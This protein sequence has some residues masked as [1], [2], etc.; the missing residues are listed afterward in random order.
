MGEKDDTERDEREETPIPV[1]ICPPGIAHNALGWWPQKVSVHT[2]VGAPCGWKVTG[3]KRPQGSSYGVPIVEPYLSEKA[4]VAM[5]KAWETYSSTTE[6]VYKENTTEAQRENHQHHMRNGEAQKAYNA[7][8]NAKHV[9]GGP[10][11]K[12]EP[13]RHVDPY[14]RDRVM[15]SG[16]GRR[17]YG[18]PK[19]DLFNPL[20]IRPVP[21]PGPG[22]GNGR[23][24]KGKRIGPYHQEWKTNG[25]WHRGEGVVMGEQM[26]D[27]T[28]G[29]LVTVCL[30]TGY[31][32]PTEFAYHPQ[33]HPIVTKDVDPYKVDSLV[34]SQTRVVIMTDHSPHFVYQNLQAVIRKRRLIYTH[35]KS[36]SAIA[37][38]LQKLLPKRTAKQNGEDREAARREAEVEA[39]AEQAAAMNGGIEPGLSARAAR[40]VSTGVT[41]GKS[42]A[43]GSIAAFI[44]E[45]ADLRKG[46]AEEARRLFKIAQIQGVQTTLGS[47]AQGISTIKRKQGRG[48]IPVSAQPVEVSRPVQAQTGLEV[49]IAGLQAATQALQG[50][51]A[52]VEAMEAERAG[53]LKENEKLKTK[54]KLLAE[55]MAGL[56]D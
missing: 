8:K 25:A 53:W 13:T 42:A 16:G 17:G 2:T 32:I 38:E 24:T 44:K 37:V 54:L 34:P 10:L 40:K 49:A 41:E 22:R 18:Y 12:R 52:T 9:V 51:K 4:A 43:K 7:R 56:E 31:D 35:R 45:H 55:A 46:S 21:P 27:L 5:G 11:K 29:G 48:D 14:G 20:P 6:A 26:A 28:Q 15:V 19:V 23:G 36:E 39:R 30:G 3:T 1:T 33:V 50:I 47:L